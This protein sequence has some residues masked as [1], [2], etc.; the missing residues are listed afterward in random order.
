MSSQRPSSATSAVPSRIPPYGPS[1]SMKYAAGTRIPTTIASPPI[2]GSGR[3]CTR[4]RSLWP[5]SSTAPM[6]G[7]SHAVAG[8]R[9]KRR[10][11][12][13]RNP[14][15]TASS[16]KSASSESRKVTGPVSQSGSLAL[17]GKP[18]LL[19]FTRS[20]PRFPLIPRRWTPPPPPSTNASPRERRKS[21]SSGSAMPGSRW[22][23]RSRRP[24]STSRGSTSTPTACRPFGITARTSW[25]FPPRAT[26][27]STATS[28]ATSDYGV[29]G[30]PRRDHDLRADAALEDAHA[31]HLLR[32]RRG[33]VGRR[34]PAAGHARRAPVDDVP[35]DDR[36]D[37]EAD[38][39]GD[40]R[41]S[42]RRRLPRLRA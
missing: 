40:R 3:S 9:M 14:Q 41:E 33:R 1:R 5:G 20:W 28:T 8:V 7:A 21:G 25:T 29:V 27:A 34:E 17:S 22:G 10:T 42:R 16:L 15:T 30:E 6:R 37:R 38:P 18:F 35:G 13:A 36:G 11:T 12:A 24:A 4:G 2:R 39:R 26:R 32:R 31:G 23:W 19:A